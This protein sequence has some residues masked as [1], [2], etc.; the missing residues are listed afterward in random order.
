MF[1]GGLGAVVLL[2]REGSHINWIKSLLA[3]I[4][5]NTSQ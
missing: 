1:V 3:T 2:D 4:S 5:E